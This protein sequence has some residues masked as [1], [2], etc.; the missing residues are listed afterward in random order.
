ML[1]WAKKT[2]PGSDHPMHDVDSAATLLAGIRGSD[3]VAALNDLSAWVESLLA[4]EGIDGAVKCEVLALIQ[5]AGAPH[6]SALLTQYLLDVDAKPMLR[7]VK[8]KALFDYAS[9][10][11]EV[12]CA[13]AQ[14]LIASKIDAPSPP[15]YAAAIVHAL[16]ACR[17]LVKVCLVHYRSVPT[18]AWTLAYS[19]HAAAE[20]A[21]CA[22]N[23][24]HPKHN[25]R[26]A[27]TPTHELLR[28]LMLQVSA[29]EM[30]SPEQIE[31]ADRA[32]QQVGSDF[33]LRPRGIADNAFCFDSGSGE[34]PA[35]AVARVPGPTTLRYFGPG[36][37]L[38]ALSR[39]EK[40]LASVTAAEMS[41][42]GK[43]IPPHVQSAT[44]AH[45]L[46]I[47][48]GRSLESQTVRSPLTGTMLVVHGYAQIWRC[49]PDV[50][51]VTKGAAALG[52]APDEDAM[53]EPPEHWP[54]RDGGG[55]ELGAEIPQLNGAWAKSGQLLALSIDNGKHWW[56][57][58]IRRM[59]AEPGQNMR[60]DI[61][62]LS[63]RPL[64]VSL[65]VQSSAENGDDFDASHGSLAF[66]A[67]QVILLPDAEQPDGKPM[68]LLPPIAWK[69]GRL[70]ETTVGGPRRC[71][72]LLRGLHRGDDHVRAQFE[73][74]AA[75][76]RTLLP[77]PVIK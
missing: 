3:P 2:E 71:L 13:S 43:D 4:V 57:G 5:A 27:T 59:H 46:H 64:A 61:V 7:E 31:V 40:Q 14:Q 53:H 58:T 69:Q 16:A 10:L 21:G 15:A 34:P 54:L 62:V 66:Y 6:V 20:A 17:T 49:L 73:W 1:E 30:M 39:L 11:T 8:W 22:A 23:V 9:A 52:I 41:A 60:A 56:L 50:E 45:L 72:R 33:T 37:A 36:L 68:L 67:A 32:A 38:E 70:Y 18:Q 74:T 77:E 29:P 51:A 42:Y 55:D 35:S 65:Q 76:R 47:W 63:R 19:L 48:G 75:L 24:I 26:S 28:L 25:Q 12:Q 44:I